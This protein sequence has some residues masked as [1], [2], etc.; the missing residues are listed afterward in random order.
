MS[1]LPPLH[2]SAGCERTRTTGYIY[3]PSVLHLRTLASTVTTSS[4][5]PPDAASA[6]SLALRCSPPCRNSIS[7]DAVITSAGTG[8]ARSITIS[9]TPHSPVVVTVPAGRHC[10][11]SSGTSV[12]LS[13]PDPGTYMLSATY[14]GI[15]TLP[16]PALLQH[17]PLRVGLSLL[18]S[19]KAPQL[20][21]RTKFTA[22]VQ[23]HQHSRST[24]MSPS[25]PP[26]RRPATTDGCVPASSA[27]KSIT[28][29]ITLPPP[30]VHS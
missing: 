19:V 24:G 25:R 20:R 11:R 1:A 3:I 15:A 16:R 6:D 26:Q 5:L 18:A 23:S 10:S 4:R 7:F 28:V 8:H 30:H 27:L 13:L 22:T 29:S 17:T 21:R 9:A 2:S 14:G 12:A